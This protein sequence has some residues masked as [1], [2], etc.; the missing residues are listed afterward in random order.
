MISIISN[1]TYQNPPPRYQNASLIKKLEQLNI[2]RSSTYVATVQTN[3]TRKYIETKNYKELC[4]S[5]GNGCSKKE[6]EQ[7]AAKMSLI[8]HGQLNTDQYTM[9]DV[10]YPTFNNIN[11]DSDSD[12]DKT[13]NIEESDID[14]NSELTDSD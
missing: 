4:I 2:A 9:S 13:I 11:T 5:F 6:G 8:L 3:F 14:I 7:N 12:T 1:Q 10:Y